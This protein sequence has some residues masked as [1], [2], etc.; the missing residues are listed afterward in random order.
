MVQ[1]I[2]YNCCNNIFAACHEPRCYTSLQ[3]QKA[4][5]GYQVEMLEIKDV[6]FNKCKCNL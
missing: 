1:V 5:K 2:K 4:T 6:K 3:W